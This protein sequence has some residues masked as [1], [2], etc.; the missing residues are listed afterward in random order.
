MRHLLELFN[1]VIYF[2][3]PFAIITVIYIRTGPGGGAVYGVGLG[4]SVT[5]IVGLNPARGMDVRLCI[6]VSCC[7][8]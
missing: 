3:H 8:V 1:T 4:R 6:S 5:G 7:P 2:V